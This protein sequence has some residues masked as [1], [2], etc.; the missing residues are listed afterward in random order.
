MKGKLIIVSGPSGS[1]TSTVTK[2]VKERLN[3]PLSI[4]A[5]TRKPRDGEIEGKDYYFLTEDLKW[6]LIGQSLNFITFRE[7]INLFK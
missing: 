1:G 5:T 7:I 3:I 6:S 4:S 2:I